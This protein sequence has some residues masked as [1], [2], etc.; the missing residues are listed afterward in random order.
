M[1]KVV[2]AVI[3][4]A[5]LAACGGG[6]SKPDTAKDQAKADNIVLRASDLPDGFAVKESSSSD[7]SGSTDS[8]S[9]ATQQQ[10]DD[11][12]EGKS[13]VSGAD[14][15]AHTTAK[16]KATYEQGTGLDSVEVEG[17]A[18][19]YDEEAIVA[20]ELSALQDPAFGDCIQPAFESSFTNEGATDVALT[21]TPTSVD[22]IGDGGAGYLVSGNVTITGVK[23]AFATELGFV[24]VGRTALTTFVTSLT[25]D[26]DHDLLT[27]SL[28][29]MA[30]RA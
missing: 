22:G 8:S 13:G 15:K 26:A 5:L 1:R 3:A 18:Q 30:G 10:F 29:A 9:D 14:D 28:S 20:K 6:S 2:V 17:E 12:V 25:G 24:R 16:A 7:S 11:C 27:R 19:L 21:V 23:V 4:V